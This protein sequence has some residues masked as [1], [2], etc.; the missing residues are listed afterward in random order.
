MCVEVLRHSD[1]VPRLH[2]NSSRACE[3]A[4]QTLP[5]RKVANNTSGGDALEHVLA[6]PGDEVAIVDDVLLAFAELQQCQ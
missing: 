2:E 4:H 3:L 5:G 1:R 6:V